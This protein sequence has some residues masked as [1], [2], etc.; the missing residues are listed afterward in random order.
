MASGDGD[1]QIVMEY[2][3]RGGDGN[4]IV[5]ENVPREWE[6]SD[7]IVMENVPRGGRGPGWAGNGFQV[8]RRLE[9]EREREAG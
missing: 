8:N 2:L 5:M 7:R 1:L 3:P 9:P 6:A 4:R